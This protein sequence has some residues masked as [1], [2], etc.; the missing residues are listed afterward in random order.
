[1]IVTI[2][3]LELSPPSY[4]DGVQNQYFSSYHYKLFQFSD[5]EDI[6]INGGDHRLLSERSVSLE[7]SAAH[8]S[9]SSCSAII[10]IRVGYHWSLWISFVPLT[11]VM[12][13]GKLTHSVGQSREMQISPWMKIRNSYVETER[14]THSG[15]MVSVSLASS[16]TH[17]R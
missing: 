17:L 7:A 16:Q 3:D 11:L 15:H 14:S 10:T 12:L 6:R 4:L 1:M 9:F 5:E 2:P 8:E 13:T